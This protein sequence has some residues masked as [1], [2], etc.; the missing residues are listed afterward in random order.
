MVCLFLFSSICVIRQKWLP[1]VRTTVGGQ[2][3]QVK[4]RVKTFPTGAAQFPVRH[5]G[6]LWG[7]DGAISGISEAMLIST[8]KA[9]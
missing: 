8:N 9:I 3:L 5:L 1:Q 7:L 6:G 2:N 4:Q